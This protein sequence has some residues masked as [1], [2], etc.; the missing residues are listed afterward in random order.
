MGHTS[1]LLAAAAALVAAVAPGCGGNDGKNGDA[2]TGNGLPQDGDTVHLNPAD[3]T[4]E[5]DNP[6]WPMRPGTRWTSRETTPDGSRQKV[7]VTITPA[8]KHVANG[9]TAREVRDTA[10]DHGQVVED[11]RDW[12]AQDRAGNVWYMGEDTKEYENGRVAST[13]GSWE[14]GVDGAQPGVIVP[15]HPRPGMTYRQEHYAGHAEDRASIVSV[16]EQAGVPAGQY[17][18]VVLTR[19]TN[20]LEPRLVE[21]KFYARGVG[22]VLAVATSGDNAREELIKTEHVR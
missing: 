14:A 16:S 20:P 17:D 19:E 3:F 18:H 1:R 13:A 11:T 7:V 4:T 2:A 21:F 9:V 15:A 22:P 12:Y 6:Y 8:T 10:T 5:I